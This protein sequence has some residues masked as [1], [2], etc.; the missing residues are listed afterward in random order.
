MV[1]TRIA[2]LTKMA[3]ISSALRR[4]LK[5]VAREAQNVTPS[6]TVTRLMSVSLAQPAGLVGRMDG[7]RDSSRA[8]RV[9]DQ[10]HG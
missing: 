3:A 6:S 9:S 8:Q 4:M 2:M 7:K 1:E 10:R 5:G